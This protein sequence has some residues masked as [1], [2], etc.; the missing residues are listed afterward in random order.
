MSLIEGRF[1]LGQM[2]VTGFQPRP[3]RFDRRPFRGEHAIHFRE[4]RSADALAPE[5]HVLGADHL[6]EIGGAQG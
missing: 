5:H 1:G 3:L 4:L 2:V 6:G